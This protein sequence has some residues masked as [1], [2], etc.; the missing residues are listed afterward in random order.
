MKQLKMNVDIV[1]A[2]Y[3]LMNNYPNPFNPSTVI[4]FS[5]PY[6]SH[7]ELN[8]YNTLGQ[9]VERLFDSN[10]S[11]GDHKVI[12]NASKFSSGIYFDEMRAASLDGRHSFR[13]VKKMV[14]IK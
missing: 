1:P 8:I 10:Q 4:K 14:Y 12:F 11:A 7:V 3:I 2:N 5:L 13:T 9:L 6:D